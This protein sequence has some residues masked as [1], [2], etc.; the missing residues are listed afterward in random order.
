[1]MKVRKKQEYIEWKEN[2]LEILSKFEPKMG[3]CLICLLKCNSQAVH[4]DY[5]HACTCSI[6]AKRIM[7]KGNCPMCRAKI[8]SVVKVL[9]D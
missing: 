4:G 8:D 3:H 9:F 6:C 7:K 2:E 5:S 1:M